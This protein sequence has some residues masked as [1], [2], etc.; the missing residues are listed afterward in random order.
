[1]TNKFI[2]L[3]PTKPF[4][5]PEGFRVGKVIVNGECIERSI[6]VL[7]KTTINDDNQFILKLQSRMLQR[8]IEWLKN[9]MIKQ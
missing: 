2:K 9:K 7:K 5:V 8:S 6:E 4:I 1:M 3:D